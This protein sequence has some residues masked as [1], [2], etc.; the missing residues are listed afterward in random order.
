MSFDDARTLFHEFGHGLHG[1]LSRVTYHRLAGTQVLRDFVELPSQLFEHWLAEP[2]VLRQH[3]RHWQTGEPIPDALVQRLQ[4]AQR[5][6]QGYETVS[7]CG[8][9]LVDLEI[10]AQSTPPADIVAFE[11][12]ALQRLC[13]PRAV[14]MRHRLPHFQHLFAGAS[15]ASGY[16]VYLWAEVLD[17]DAY[18]AFIEAGNPFDAD[19]AARLHRHIYASGD[20]VAPQAAYTAFRGRLP[21]LVPLLTKRGL[22]DEGAPSV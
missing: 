12:A 8:S 4:A 18:D 9:A 10:H 1:L 7:Y 17:A 22:L 2:Q 5:W 19:V 3:A 21:S 20:T 15:Y 11:Q 13:M 14:G 6:G 16:Y